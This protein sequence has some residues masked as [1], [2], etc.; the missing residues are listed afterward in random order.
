MSIGDHSSITAGASIEGDPLVSLGQRGEGELGRII[1]LDDGHCCGPIGASSRDGGICLLD[2]ASLRLELVQ[3][4]QQFLL[5]GGGSVCLCQRCLDRLEIDFQ[6]RVVVAHAGRDQV[7]RE[8]E[9]RKAQHHQSQDYR[10]L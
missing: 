5:V 8:K 6:T 9:S 3:G 4:G 2:L 7:K 1:A 10:P